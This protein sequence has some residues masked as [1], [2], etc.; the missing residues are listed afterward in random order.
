[1]RTVFLSLL[2]AS[3]LV[4]AALGCCWNRTH[5]LSFG[6]ASAL[7][8]AETGCDHEHDAAPDGHHSHGPCKSH[9]HC[10]G[11]CNYLPAQKSQVGKWQPQVTIEL[12]SHATPPSGWQVG[13]RS[14]AVGMRASFP[15]P[16]RL[17]LLHQILLI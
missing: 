9:S 12:A 7:A 13:A 11:M 4:H 3:L 17:H 10:H 15:P 1:M 5:G 2:S 14:F 16:L 6:D 8:C